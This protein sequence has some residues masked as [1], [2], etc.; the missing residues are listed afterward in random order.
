[1]KLLGFLVSSFIGIVL[2]IGLLHLVFFTPFPTSSTSSTPTPAWTEA[3][4]HLIQLVDDTLTA[5]DPCEAGDVVYH[6][7]NVDS[8]SRLLAAPEGKALSLE[9]LEAI[10]EQGAHVN[11]NWGRGRERRAME[12]VGSDGDDVLVELWVR[13]CIFSS[14]WEGA[15]ALYIMDRSGNAQLVEH[16]SYHQPHRLDATWIDDRWVALVN[17]QTMGM[18]G[19]PYVIWHITQDHDLWLISVELVLVPDEV[20]TC[21]Y[22]LGYFSGFLNGY[23]RFTVTQNCVTMVPPCEYKEGYSAYGNSQE[24]TTWYEWTGEGY[25]IDK[26][27]RIYTSVAIQE[28]DKPSETYFSDDGWQYFCQPED[29]PVSGY[30]FLHT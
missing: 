13:I 26:E 6:Q 10:W 21:G 9:V 11:S 16:I 12:L 8:V 25:A 3:E 29:L 2:W 4:R 7:Q 20:L 24:I 5:D 18:I 28:P 22:N 19:Q 15:Y 14:H 27:T 17:T 1:M 23:Q 30:R